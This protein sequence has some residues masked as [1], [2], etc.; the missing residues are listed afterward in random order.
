M[1]EKIKLHF[2]GEHALLSAPSGKKITA[3]QL[4]ENKCYL[5]NNLLFVRMIISIVG[6][7]VYYSD[8]YGPGKCSRHHF[9]S[10]C[11][12]EATEEEL[13]FLLNGEIP[14]NLK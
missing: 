5:H 12:Y 7:T 13:A 8:E 6:D 9:A 3:S 14:S 10:L 1:D 2:N 4:E 11:R